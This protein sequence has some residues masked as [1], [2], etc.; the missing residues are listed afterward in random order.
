MNESKTLSNH[1]FW[2]AVA[3][4]DLNSVRNLLEQDPSL[5][6]RDFR[7]PKEQDPHTFGFPIV[8]AADTNNLEMIDLL[9]EFGP[10]S[11]PKAP[12]KSNRTPEPS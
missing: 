12:P 5:A 9:L 6:Q 2:I 1:P 10:T 11:T 7:P 4:G 8:K 3:E